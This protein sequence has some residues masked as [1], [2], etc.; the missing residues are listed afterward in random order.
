MA[1]VLPDKLKSE[2]IDILQ[3]YFKFSL[4]A[5][6]SNYLFIMFIYFISNS[7]NFDIYERNVFK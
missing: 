2:Q 1:M 3:H 6:N 4:L 7:S 5:E